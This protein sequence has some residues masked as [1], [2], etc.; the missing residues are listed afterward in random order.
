LKKGKNMPAPK[1]FLKTLKRLVEE[2]P[3]DQTEALLMT[4]DS[5]LTRFTPA[6]VH[7]HVAERNQTLTP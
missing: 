3:A 4:E 5:S 1:N 7:Q 2:S 6:S